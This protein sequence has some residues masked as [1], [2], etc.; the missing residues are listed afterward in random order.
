MEF[1]W[2]IKDFLAGKQVKNGGRSKT[3]LTDRTRDGLMSGNQPKA[4]DSL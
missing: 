3:L 2:E 1:S 4:Q